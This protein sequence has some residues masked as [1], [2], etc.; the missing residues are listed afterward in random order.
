MADYGDGK[1]HAATLAQFVGQLVDEGAGCIISRQISVTPHKDNQISIKW[2][3]VA[4]A[5]GQVKK[6]IKQYKCE[7]IHKTL[8][9]LLNAGLIS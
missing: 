4:V 7:S 3:V 8:I 1:W 9:A 6:A 5:E 2:E